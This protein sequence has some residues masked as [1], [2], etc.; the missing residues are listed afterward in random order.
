M[1]TFWGRS[2]DEQETAARQ[3]ASAIEALGERVVRI[4][5]EADA[6]NDDVP[7]VP[8][9]VDARSHRYF[10]HHVKLLLPKDADL[11]RLRMLVLPQGARLSRN[12]RR[13]RNDGLEE[14][15]VTQRIF[16]VS[17][18]E[19]REA[20]ELLVSLLVAGGFQILKTEAEF[21]LSDTNLSLDTG[22]ID[23]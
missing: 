5:T 7:R 15:F 21:V 8:G 22:W 11:E 17:Q 14:R 18:P 19:A 20:L 1:L 2:L 23:A 6:D 4:K 16:H 10:E 9:D 13:Q 12:A 3:M